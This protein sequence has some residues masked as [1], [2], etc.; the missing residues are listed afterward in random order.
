MR[1]TFEGPAILPGYAYRLR[2]VAEHALFPEAA[3]FVAQIRVS[4]SSNAVLADISSAA[5]G[6]ERISDTELELV[7][8]P[9]ETAALP[10]GRVVLDIV[11]TDLTPLLHLGVFLELPVMQ[12]VTRE[13]SP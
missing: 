10:L 7:L 5:G 8:S 11:R 9:A 13:V 6:F 2:L 1:T 3:R 4:P 12:P